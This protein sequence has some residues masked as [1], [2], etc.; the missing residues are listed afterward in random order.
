MTNYREP[1]HYLV[2]VSRFNIAGTKRYIEE[3]PVTTYSPEMAKQ[4][5]KQTSKR[6]GVSTRVS[7]LKVLGV[8]EI[9]N[10]EYLE[11]LRR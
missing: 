10:A 9:S 1:K 6:L 8:R 3:L 2:K 4:H 5:I 7:G 11:N